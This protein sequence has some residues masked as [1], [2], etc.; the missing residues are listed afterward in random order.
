MTIEG[1]CISVVCAYWVMMIW[2]E[3]VYDIWYMM[4]CDDET[5]LM[6][7]W[8]SVDERLRSVGLMTDVN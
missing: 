5:I 7:V 4:K 2:Y 6:M 8:I 3:M 1:S